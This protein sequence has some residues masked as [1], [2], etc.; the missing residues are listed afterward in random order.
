M[1]DLQKHN[2]QVEAFRQWWLGLFGS[3]ADLGSCDE[4]DLERMAHDVGVLTSE[5]RTL[6]QRGPRSADLLL[7]RMEALD[8]NQSEVAR[9]ERATFQ[10]LQRVCSLCDCKRPCARDLARD[11]FNRSWKA[12]CPNAQTLTS[13]SS[14]PWASRRE[15]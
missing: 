2:S 14:L 1:V 4:H 15:W 7:R 9:T 3:R 5:L 12:Y 6:A 10:D 13:L 8:L 11:P